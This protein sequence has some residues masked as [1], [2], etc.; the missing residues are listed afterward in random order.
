MTLPE[1]EA[2]EKWKTEESPS[3]MLIS[4]GG[5]RDWIHY[6]ISAA[7]N[8]RRSTIYRILFLLPTQPKFSVCWARDPSRILFSNAESNI[9]IKKLCVDENF[10]TN[11]VV[12]IGERAEEEDIRVFIGNGNSGGGPGCPGQFFS[13]AS[14]Y[15][16]YR[17]SGYRRVDEANGQR[18][19]GPCYWLVRW[20]QSS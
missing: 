11:S 4:S 12:A 1:D 13:S 17:E 14:L 3:G 16:I 20:I 10:S 19:W 7:R 6:V 2:G 8:L 15:Y 9:T 18:R 5:G